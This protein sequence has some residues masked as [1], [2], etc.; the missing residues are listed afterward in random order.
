MKVTREDKNTD[1]IESFMTS[2]KDLAFDAYRYDK[3]DFQ[4]IKRSAIT[5]RSLL[6]TN[7][8]N[9]SIL[10][11]MDLNT[12]KFATFAKDFSKFDSAISFN[13]LKFARFKTTNN[14]VAKPSFYDTMIFYPDHINTPIDYLSFESWWNQPLVIF[15]D[16]QK[17]ED[18]SLTRA[19]LVLKEANQDGPGH[20][21]EKIDAIYQQYKTGSTGFV[22]GGTYN[23]VVHQCYIGGYNLN[24]E[25][26]GKP[27]HVQDVTLALTRQIVHELLITINTR[28]NFLIKYEP[29]LNYNFKRKLNYL[30]WWMTVTK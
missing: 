27:T 12:I 2:L 13:A 18:K 4:A 17:G 1:L 22:A 7:G 11:Q 20:F 5:L 9:K 29:D 3:G 23:P 26:L 14:V 10:E 21:D 25:T 8:R 19:H 24:Q 15:K 6:Y 30:A 28:T 16:E